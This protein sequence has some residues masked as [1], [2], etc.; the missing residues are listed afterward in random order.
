M[1]PMPTCTA[2]NSMKPM[3]VTEPL[4][5]SPARAR[6]TLAVWLLSDGKPGHQ[7]QL[8]GLAQALSRR[9][10]VDL[11]WVDI[12]S[13]SASWTDLL[14]GR[15]PDLPGTGA[16]HLAIGAGHGTHRQLLAL[17]RAS[18]CM[19]CV[20]MRPS[21]PLR[22]FDAAIIPRHDDPPA[23]SGHV[24]VTDGVLNPVIPA[25]E[26]DVS[27]GLILLGGPSRHYHFPLAE[28][29]QQVTS[30]CA[31]FPQVDWTASTS[32]RT[33]AGTADSLR[34][35]ALDNL[36]LVD[37]TDTPTGWVAQTLGQCAQAWITEDS[38]SMVYEAL[39]A[40]IATGLITLPAVRG[41]RLQR[42]LGDLQQNGRLNRLGDVL[43]GQ[44]PERPPRP[45]QEADRAAD[46][47]LQRLPQ[48][49][50]A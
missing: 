22:C 27:R 23:N 32:R 48:A 28:V 19:T 15:Y 45:L 42:G 25:S 49:A 35:M 4:P 43:A 29:C 44:Q 37:H 26:P 5:S 34:A 31:R 33:P 2:S 9:Q 40:G 10:P 1:A 16:P 17:G 38:V 36:Q 14:L 7:A 20:L 12:E 41:G 46:W 50:R 47:L 6:K 13:R 3:P 24:L 21:L 11:T 8:H 18:H 30:L 39:S